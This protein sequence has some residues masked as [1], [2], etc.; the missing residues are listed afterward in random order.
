LKLF[1]QLAKQFW[2]FWT[3]LF[4]GMG[5][6][7]PAKQGAIEENRIMAATFSSICTLLKKR[8]PSTAR[9]KQIVP[10]G[11]PKCDQWTASASERPDSQPLPRRQQHPTRKQLSYF[12]GRGE[13]WAWASA[14]RASGLSFGGPVAFP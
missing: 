1:W 2:L 13:I 10:R 4:F 8:N 7:L 6:K 3:T 9:A 12:V 11:L 5:V 14:A